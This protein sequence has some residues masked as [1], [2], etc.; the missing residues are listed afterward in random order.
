M[1]IQRTLDKVSLSNTSIP[2][3]VLSQN[4][5]SLNLSD[6]GLVT[7]RKKLIFILSKRPD[8]F[9][10]TEVKCYNKDS[11]DIIENHISSCKNG[12][13]T[14][15]IN[16]TKRER[17]TAILIPLL[18]LVLFTPPATLDCPFLQNCMTIL[19]D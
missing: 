4:I 6:P 13:Y 7:L 8:I 17:G 15:L 9:F 14:L 1:A 3:T 5:R 12:P 10:L 19:E 16:S 2:I 18:P 11:I